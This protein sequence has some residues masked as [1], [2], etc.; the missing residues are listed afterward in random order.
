MLKSLLPKSDFAKNVLTLV[1]G[2]TIAQAIPLAI[3]PILSR[4]YTKSDFGV[5][6]IF[7]AIISIL[8]SIANG[9]YEL[10][11]MQPKKDEDAINIFALG[12]IILSSVSV[13][14][15]L[16][17]F[18]F[19]APIVTL[20]KDERIGFW[21]Y[22]VPITVFFI[23][24][25]NLLNYFNNRKKYY[26]DLAKANVLRA[27]VLASVQLGVGFIKKGATGLISGQI[28]SQLSANM[29]LIKNIT[30]DKTLIKSIKKPKIISLAKAYNRF[31]KYDLWSTLFNVSA[32]QIPVLL[33][34]DQFSV[35]IVG[36]Y[37]FAFKIVSTP[38][39]LIGSSINQVF[40]QSSADIKDQ[41][42]AF[43]NMVYNTYKKLLLLAVIPF[44]I[45]AFY[46]DY[47]FGF[48]FGKQ[49]IEAGVYTQILSPWL[50]LAFIASPLSTVLL[51]LNR[52]DILLRINIALFVL[53]TSSIIIGGIVYQNIFI[54]LVL[55]SVSGI[56]VYFFTL[57][58]IFLLTQ[59]N[60]KSLFLH[61]I[62]YILP[63]I[64]IG[65]SRYILNVWL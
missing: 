29:R 21:L 64:G 1:T 49:W 46:S 15:T 52:Q 3:S 50:L 14:L 13:L 57:R 35:A 17:I 27:I 42:T 41:P 58:H 25:F 45:L 37:A 60:L 23:G 28:V 51:S 8:S 61:T 11:I 55:L 36:L 26:K 34:A 31:P 54:T 20:L 53:R 12:F 65:L 22:F 2:T 47:I 5:L 16:I 6:A 44:S 56:I 32:A 59:Q 4:L 39:S 7:V 19:H 40:Y 63:I 30:K 10:A 33:I 48:V 62:K 43:K 24:L 18:V 38:A 9:R